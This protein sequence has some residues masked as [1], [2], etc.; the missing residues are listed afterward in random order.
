MRFRRNTHDA[1]GVYE[2]T[3][4]EQRAVWDE[5]GFVGHMLSVSQPMT[6]DEVMAE[7]RRYAADFPHDPCS[8]LPAK[9]ALDLVRLI[10]AGLVEVVS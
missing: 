3:T 6:F 9:H 1:R 5:H 7:V 2:P 4:P 8:V 10:E